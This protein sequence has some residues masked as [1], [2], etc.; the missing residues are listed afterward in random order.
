[1]KVMTPKF[2]GDPESGYVATATVGI[3]V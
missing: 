2:R 1:M 3:P